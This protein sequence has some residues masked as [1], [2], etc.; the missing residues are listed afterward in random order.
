[1]NTTWL[2]GLFGLLLLVMVACTPQYFNQQQETGFKSIV[3]KII[4]KTQSGT[5]GGVWLLE[6]EA[7][8]IYEVLLSI[9]NLGE[10]YSQYL[11][12]VDIGT[13]IQV[14]GETLFLNEYE[15]IIA[16]TLKIE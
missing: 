13:V 5:D 11:N 1:M 4:S 10:T 9:P 7:G 3:G 2:F 14:S 6:T 15:R 12:Q 16:K 8:D